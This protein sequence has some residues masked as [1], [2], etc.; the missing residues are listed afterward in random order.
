MIKI[1]NIFSGYGAKEVI[2]GITFEIKKGSFNA[3]IGKNGSGK[4]TLLKTIAKI[5]AP[6]KGNIYI[7][8]KN[9]AGTSLK[10][11][12]LNVAYMPQVTDTSTNFSVFDFVALGRPFNYFGGFSKQDLD[13][14]TNAL[15]LTDTEQF[16]NIKISS[17]SG[18]EVQRVALA[19]T[20]A[21]N[22]GII[23]LDEPTSHLDI[24]AE[25]QIFELL[26]RL[27]NEGK[28]IIATIHDL[29]A[30]AEYA[31]NII[32]IDSGKLF[33][34]GAPE[35]VFNYKDI[36][37]VYNTHVLVKTNPISQKP[38]VIPLSQRNLSK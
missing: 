21:Q 35:Q 27:N 9:I 17:L 7:N 22:T 29:N 5:I 31:D 16:K 12:A 23:L 33:S 37:T 19:Q 8:G 15:R 13:I 3:L 34:Q 24:G 11:F 10:E 30:A 28:T 26:R 32:F 38:Y 14:V 18:G 1:E 20:I 4:T 36:E 6:S 2:K 25:A